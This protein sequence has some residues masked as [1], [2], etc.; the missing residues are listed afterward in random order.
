M[1]LTLITTSLLKDRKM[2]WLHD[3]ESHWCSQCRCSILTVTSNGEPK[4]ANIWTLFFWPISF[5]PFWDDHQV[6]SLSFES[7]S[8]LKPNVWVQEMSTK[9]N[10]MRG[11]ADVWEIQQA[12]GLPNKI[13]STQFKS[14][15]CCS[16]K[17]VSWKACYAKLA[18]S[19]RSFCG[20]LRLWMGRI[21]FHPH[22]SQ[23]IGSRYQ[24]G[25]L[26]SSKRSHCWLRAGTSAAWLDEWAWW[27][28][29]PWSW[30]KKHPS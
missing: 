28:C 29:P 9:F 13:A 17:T 30:Q 20:I 15:D 24:P 1:K 18:N 25:S 23:V 12:S 11:S 14:V 3:I 6:A 27:L 5:V 7:N 10:C 19:K 8:K 2:H 4:K 26:T 22:T 16:K 21:A